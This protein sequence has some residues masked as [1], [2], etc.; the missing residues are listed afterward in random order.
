MKTG[1]RT[2]ENA[3]FNH[4]TETRDMGVSPKNHQVALIKNNHTRSTSVRPDMGTT[5]FFVKIRR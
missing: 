3:R 1:D 4:E 5:W 2:K